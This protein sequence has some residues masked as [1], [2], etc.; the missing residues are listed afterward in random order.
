MKKIFIFLLIVIVIFTSLYFW[1]KNGIAPVDSA[2]TSSKTFI[3][4]KGRGTRAIV[5]D[6]KKEGL[7]RDPIVFFLLLKK[8]G[9]DEKIQAGQFILSPSMSAE[10]VIK[11]LQVGTFDIT[12]TIPEGKRATEIGEILK[13]KM[14]KYDSAWIE[15]LSKNEGY[16]F[17]DTYF[18]KVDSNIEQII[19]IMKRNFYKKYGEVI[20]NT[21]LSRKDIVILASLIEREAKHSEDRLLISSVIYNRLNQDMKLDIDA[22]VQYALGFD[23]I[24]N[25]WWKKNL[26]YEDL[27]IDSPY[28][29]YTN[30]GLPP[31]PISNPGLASLKAAGSPAKTDFIF[32]VSDQQGKTYYAQTLEEH[33]ENVR[34]YR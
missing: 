6:L 19:D 31:G 15:E 16:L 32:Y 12:I 27:K 21:S 28:N 9:V 17:P 33:N 24:E 22:S 10:E 8:E 30:P 25:V 5:D 1:W 14:S 7:I 20:N 4:M 23:S 34:K 3:V 26:T 2:N 29:T 13:I 11:K 18:F